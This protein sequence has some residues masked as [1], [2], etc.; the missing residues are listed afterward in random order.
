M[1]DFDISRMDQNLL[2]A[3]ASGASVRDAAKKARMSERSAYRRLESETFRRR[4]AQARGQMFERAVG[5]LA[6][7][8]VTAVDVLKELLKANSKAYDLPLA[9]RFLKAV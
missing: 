7:A 6:D 2:V 1:A 5:S 9:R 4:L 8:S 3:L